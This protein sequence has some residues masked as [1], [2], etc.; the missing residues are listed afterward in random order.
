MFSP[1]SKLLAAGSSDGIAR[2]RDPTIGMLKYT[3]KGHVADTAYPWSVA[4]IGF[5]PS[6]QLLAFGY[7]DNVIDL[8]NI[9]TGVLT[10]TLKLHEGV[11]IGMIKSIAF[12]SDGKLLA[13]GSECKIKLWEIATCTLKHI[14]RENVILQSVAFL[15]DGK[16]LAS[17][18]TEDI[19]LW[20]TA[21]G[22]LKRTVKAA[23]PHC[24]FDDGFPFLF[25]ILQLN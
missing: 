12:S 18:S 20:D 7:Y 14:M 13:A 19:K 15:P 16:L 17:G 5:S 3:L 9:A 1:D 25:P 4:T 10:A 23:D 21:T 8:W 11:T 22:V 24:G 2:P 6:C